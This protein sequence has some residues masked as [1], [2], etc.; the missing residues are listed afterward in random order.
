MNSENKKS[1]AEDILSE[2]QK[3]YGD[4][5]VE[6]P[7]AE[8]EP[9]EEP[10]AKAEPVE[11]PQA[12]AEPVEEPQAKA[13]PQ[14]E[15]EPAHQTHNMI[16]IGTKPIMSYVTATLTQLASLPI[17]TIAG[18]GKRITQAIDV[19][20]MIVK[21]MNEV[22]YEIGDV[23]ISSDSLVSKDGKKRSVSKIEIDLKNS[24]GN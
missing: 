11:E 10:Q 2:F 18:R 1:D 21:R 4:E 16:F 9:V 6:E 15:S 17:V 22:G 12:K 13:E 20:Q 19:S 14:V 23:R 7:Q 5:P 8:A 24:S 3:T